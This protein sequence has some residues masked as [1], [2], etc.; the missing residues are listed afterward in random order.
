MSTIQKVLILGFVWPEPN[1]SAAGSR[2]MQLIKLFQEQDWAITFAS[3]AKESDFQFDLKTIGIQTETIAI[4][5]DNFDEFVKNLNP[6]IVI[7]DRFMIEEQF[8]W[9][10]AEN[11]PE[12]LRILDTEDLHCLRNA[13][14]NALKKNRPFQNSDLFQEITKREIA[15]ILRCDLS[16]IISEVEMNLLQTV[17]KVDSSL[18]YYL[19]FLLEFLSKNEISNWPTFEERKDFIFIGNFL[20]KPNWD[21]VQYLHQ[22][23][24]PKIKKELPETNLNIYGAYPSQKVTQLHNPKQGF[25]ILGRAENALQVMSNAKV[26]LAPL[27][28]GAG[29][30]GKFIEAM[31]CGT[32]CI[33]TNIGAESMFG[34]LDWNGFICENENEIVEKTILLYKNKN[35]WLASQKNGIKILNTRY[36]KT[37]FNSEFINRLKFLKNNLESHRQ[38]N[39]IGEILRHHTLNSTKYMSRWI[40]EKN[41]K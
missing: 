18:L 4:N 9:R 14:E 7:F 2:M 23:I 29:I 20:H 11:C 1:S 40:I 31:Q 13:R 36:L 30:K 41:K 32:P 25:Y 8:G 35:T 10:I 15:S 39:F 6:S 33:T 26:I 17:F 16:L 22:S 38:N 12:A 24:W 5:D 28:F 3:P 34:D 19:P 21:A 37:L 27:R